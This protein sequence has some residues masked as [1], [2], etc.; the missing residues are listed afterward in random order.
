MLVAALT[1]S[2][3][4]PQFSFQDGQATLRRGDQVALSSPQEGLWSVATAWEDGWPARWHHAQPTSLTQSGDWQIAKGTLTLPEGKLELSDSY[5]VE[6]NLVRCVR[7]WEWH[8]QTPLNHVTLSVRWNM[9]QGQGAKPFLPGISY[10]GNP[11]GAM[12][13]SCVPIQT[14]A[15]GEESFYEEHRYAM[16]FASLENATHGVALHSIPS[17]P[18]GAHKQDQWWTLGLDT[19]QPASVGIGA[20]NASA[21]E[22]KLGVKCGPM[23]ERQELGLTENAYGV[24]I[25]V[26]QYTDSVTPEQA[27][28]IDDVVERHPEFGW[29][30]DQQW[31]L[32]NELYRLVRPWVGSK[33]VELVNKIMGLVRL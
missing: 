23:F 24:F 22:L 4:A 20:G 1:G 11:S 3:L 19:F 18:A 26:R 8:G 28:Q 6:G 29:D 31:S 9:H 25:V 16:P 10:F 30:L 15:P 21:T 32:R 5:R 33:M 7:R 14:M 27:K 17:M 2:L 12:T 13:K